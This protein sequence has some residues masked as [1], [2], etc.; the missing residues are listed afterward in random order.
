MRAICSNFA[1]SESCCRSFPQGPRTKCRV[2]Q[3][4]CYQLWM[5]RIAD[6]RMNF[7]SGT[8]P[9]RMAL[10]RS[11]HQDNLGAKFAVFSGNEQGP[12]GAILATPGF[13]SNL[14]VHWNEGFMSI[15]RSLH[16]WRMFCHRVL[17]HPQMHFQ[18]HP[19][20]VSAE[21]SQPNKTVHGKWLLSLRNDF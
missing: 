19:I 7:P 8:S 13:D 4:D 21:K 2:R 12:V 5:V 15:F 14:L 1:S 3:A 6:R 11:I 20:S 17:R 18:E 16:F 10:L 9:A